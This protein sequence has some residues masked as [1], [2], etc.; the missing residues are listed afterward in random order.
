MK[1]DINTEHFRTKQ[2]KWTSLAQLILVYLLV[3]N[4]WTVFPYTFVL[5][6][7]IILILTYWK[8][9]SF[10]PLGLKIKP[11]IL[12]IIGITLL[13]FVIVEPVFD[14]VI[15]PLINWLANESPDYSS[16]QSIAYDTSRYLKYIGLIW[17]IAAFG[18]ELMFRGF[19]FLQLNVLLPPMKFKRILLVIASAMMFA[20]PHA[21]QGLSGMITTFVFGLIFGTTYIRFNYNLWIVIVLHGLIDSFFITLAYMDQ[22][23]YYKISFF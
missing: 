8:Y 17:I 2:E 10:S 4:P 9:K 16:F 13:P 19:L 12:K 3:F 6:S 15:Q 1:F 20:L 14:F 7:S 11:G 23:D 18:E 5:I 21:Y 22:L